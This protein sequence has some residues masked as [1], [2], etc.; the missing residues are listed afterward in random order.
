M[1]SSPFAP[2]RSTRPM[3]SLMFEY[4][5]LPY[6]V[7][8]TTNTGIDGEMMPDIGPTAWR[9]WHCARRMAPSRS[10]FSAASAESAHRS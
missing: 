10:I 4:A 8:F 3:P 6:A 2:K 1:T 9:S 7:F 5:T